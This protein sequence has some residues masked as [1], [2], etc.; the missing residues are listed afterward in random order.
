MRR[1]I[2]VFVRAWAGISILITG[3]LI[4]FAAYRNFAESSRKHTAE[5]AAYIASALEFSGPESWGLPYLES[6]PRERRDLRLTLIAGDGRVLFDT[7]ARAED[8]ENH[9]DRP[10]VRAALEGGFGESLRFSGTLGKETYYYA[11]KLGERAAALSGSV[12][13]AA[14]T[15]DSVFAV[16]L[17]L[18]P[19]SAA[20]AAAVFILTAW[21]ASGIT[22]KIVAPVNRIDLDNPENNDVYEEF[23]PLLSRLKKQNEAIAAQIGEIQK[24]R[25]EFEAVTDHMREGL[26]VLDQDTRIIFCNRSAR[27][28]LEIRDRPVESRSVFTVRR[29]EPFRQAV[30]KALGGAAA[31]ASFSTGRRRVRLFANPVADRGGVQGLVLLI[32]DVT[33]REDR[34]RL[35]REFSA[36]VSHELKTPL[37]SISGRAEIMAGGL[38]KA[39]DMPRFAGEIYREAQR[40]LSLINDIMTLSSLEEGE[41]LLKEKVELSGFTEKILER[42]R[43]AAESRDISLFLEAEPSEISGI[44]RVLD[45]MIFNLLDNAVKYN[46]EGGKIRVSVRAAPGETVLS[47]SDT[48]PGIGPD[49]QERVFERF[50]RVDQSRSG[51]VPGTG[52]GLAI[53]KHGAALHEAALEL[54]SDGKTGSEFIL[55]FPGN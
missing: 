20:V 25:L 24:R 32:L 22:R 41:G 36:N 16:M 33:E 19:G 53:V 17:G 35:R 11:V 4:Y 54:R 8:M 27:R 9:R 34:E 3:G 31:E 18:V 5:A 29:D 26:L 39:G 40:L 12:L 45:Q 21:A 44:P 2:L 14:H 30:E 52:L 23:T 50:Y 42:I 48:G 13:R 47:V 55:R 1:T 37:M 49:E 46:R 10:E 15:T 51:A 43:A 28:L 7:G 6:L 38:V